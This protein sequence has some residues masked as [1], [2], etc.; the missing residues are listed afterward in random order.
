MGAGRRE[1][2]QGSAA[3]TDKDSVTLSLDYSM[4]EFSEGDCHHNRRW[5]GKV[6]ELINNVR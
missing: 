2:G 1:R 3:A 4:G 6:V 5:P